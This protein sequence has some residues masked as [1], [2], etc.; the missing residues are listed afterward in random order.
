MSRVTRLLLVLVLAVT[1]A[2]M[3]SSLV[4]ARAGSTEGAEGLEASPAFDHSGRGSYSLSG[5]E[6]TTP[7][8]GYDGNVAIGPTEAGENAD[9]NSVV[10]MWS[11]CSI[12]WLAE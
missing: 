4:Y 9:E 7:R 3:S 2:A 6:D 12:V 8:F 10:K 11:D 5:E 1:M